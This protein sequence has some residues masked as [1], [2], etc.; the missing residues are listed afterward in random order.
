MFEIST[1]F[2]LFD[3]LR[4]PCRLVEA[5]P[6][7]PVERVAAGDGEAALHWP[8]E[9]I[10]RRAAAGPAAYALGEIPILGRVLPQRQMEVLT[11]QLRGDWEP[12]EV[13]RDVD[14]NVV[15]SLWR[16][17]DGTTLLPFDPNELALNLRTERYLRFDGP[18]RST[19]VVS[20]ARLGYYYVRPF[21]PRSAQLAFRRM[22][23]RLQKRRRFPRWPADSALDELFA[24]LLNVIAGLS[25][26]GV[27]TIAPWPGGSTWA[28]VLTHDV[29]GRL[30]YENL[31]RLL[32]IE[33]E[34]G[35]RSSWNFVPCNGY[36]VERRVLDRIAGAGFEI[37]VHG[38][39]HDGRDVLPG[40]LSGR[41]PAM[42]AYAEHWRAVGF[43]SPGT[44]RSP[45]LLPRL[46]FDYDSSFA[47]TAPFEPQPGGCCTWFP[48]LLEDL[49]ELPI[50]LEQDHTLFDL[51]RHHDETV[52]LEKARAIRDGRG[53]ALLLTHPDYVANPDLVDAYRG[54]LE[55]FAD[56]DTAWKALPREVSGWWR[57]RLDSQLVDVG[58]EWVVEGPAAEDARIELATRSVAYA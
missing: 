3:H 13:V 26:A 53:M 7:L 33:L 10:L 50:T 1:R 23:S 47:D 2:L 39:F 27:P 40:T 35:Y 30:G 15:T 16:A 41:L 24:A 20:T 17:G 55:H 18:R 9:E 22:L 57:R 51:L 21:I 6:A 48:Y 46:G 11:R 56:D 14:G 5:D 34:L 8:K 4:V 37:G 54:F 31:D 44:I 58:G 52:W 25:E 28:L 29:E 36:V 38:L 12:G 19:S 45:H 32:D 42:R 49:V 43:R